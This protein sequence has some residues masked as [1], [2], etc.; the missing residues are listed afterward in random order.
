MK[1]G[2]TSLC[3]CGAKATIRCSEIADRL[4]LPHNRCPKWVCAHGGEWSRCGKHRHLAG[5]MGYLDNPEIRA[6]FERFVSDKGF[7]SW[8]GIVD[9]IGCWWRNNFLSPR[10]QAQYTY[11]HDIARI[12]PVP[13]PFPHVVLHHKPSGRVFKS[14]GGVMLETTPEKK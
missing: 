8:A 2:E 13:A 14:V 3:D 6:D 10:C 7:W 4:G 5:T 9:R 1:R 11:D 12:A